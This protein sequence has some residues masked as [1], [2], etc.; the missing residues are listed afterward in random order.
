MASLV[1]DH[2]SNTIAVISTDEGKEIRVQVGGLENALIVFEYLDVLTRG[3]PVAATQIDWSP[4]I[5]EIG[6][7]ELVAAKF[8]LSSLGM[9]EP[10]SMPGFTGMVQ[11]HP[12]MD[13]E[14][15][16]RDVV[17]GICAND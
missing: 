11:V 5:D 16:V 1:P 4:L 14:T 9:L 3:R 12:T 6:Y 10:E 15:M 17:E 8:L 13:L 7:G 2:I